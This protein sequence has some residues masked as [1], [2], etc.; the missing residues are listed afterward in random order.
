[1]P[2]QPFT[3]GPRAHATHYPDS[4]GG[5]QADHMRWINGRPFS[6]QRFWD[7]PGNTVILVRTLVPNPMPGI[8]EGW[9]TI[10]EF[11]SS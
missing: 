8:A 11:T 1:M 10:H 7:A 2:T 4:Q 3:I 5:G 9:Q 6:F